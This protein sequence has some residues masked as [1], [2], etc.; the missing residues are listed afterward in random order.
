MPIEKTI[1]I[2]VETAQA[3][4]E[5]SSLN[6]E[7]KKSAQD[8]QQIGKNAE[9]SVPGFNKLTI[10]TKAF[11]TA[12]KATGIGLVVAAFVKLQEALGRNQRVMDTFNIVTE[13]ISLTFQDLVNVVVKATDKAVKFFNKVGKVIK[14]FVKQD[15][16][17][18]TSSYE[19]NNRET[20]T[21][22]QR[23]RRLAKEIVEL[24]KE[25]KLAEAQ[26]R[27]L[28]LTYQK[29]AEIQ[30]QIRDD[31]NLT[32][33]ER[34]A[35]NEELGRILDEQFEEERR[36]A[37]KKIQLA[38]TELDKN[39][40]NVDLQI[41]LTNAKSDLAELD[42]RITSQ[43][44]EQLV[45]LTALQNEYNEAVNNQGTIQFRNLETSLNSLQTEIDALNEVSKTRNITQEDY[46][47]RMQLESQR[48][49]LIDEAE[50]QAK[51][52][53]AQSVLSSLE[54]LAGEGTGAAKAAA[55]AQILIS[56]AAG[57]ANSI[58]GATAAAAAA[59]P[60]APVVTPLLIA[61]LVGQVL[62]G[63]AQAKQVLRKVPG[64]NDSSP[65]PNVD[66][67]TPSGVGGIGGL[68]PN[69]ESIQGFDTPETPPV[70]AFVIEN[71]ISNSQAL[72]EELEIQ[73]TL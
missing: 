64:P 73:A 3:K 1:T 22:I 4:E 11:G 17:G 13:T 61:Q 46:T 2:R 29:E 18:L 44:S 26:Q 40:E 68:V 15:L 10:S 34:I 9:N 72:Q 62:A 6:A 60:A 23:N 57:I 39:K 71:D 51:L 36:L 45:N 55:M 33:E 7:I 30:R 69:M 32:F 65:E 42:E 37:L 27:L 52:S 14:N 20:E 35:A 31:I 19:A 48:R 66:S 49:L 63:I 25:V 70:Q 38:Q 50:K 59:G 5:L 8:T 21:A 53:T 56:T 47:R 41:A 67:L 24:R 28:Q 54:A 58:Q 16:D 12:L 43:R